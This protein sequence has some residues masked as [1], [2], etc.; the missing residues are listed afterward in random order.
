MFEDATDTLVIGQIV[1]NGSAGVSGTAPV[2]APGA[3]NVLQAGGF[4]AEI[5]GYV[6]GD[7]I[8][9]D[10]MTVSS[11]SVV[12]GNTVDLFGPGNVSLGSL[13]FFT[14]SGIEGLE[15]RG[16]GGGG[17]DASASPQARG[18]RRWTGWCGSRTCG[19]GDRAWSTADGGAEPIV[20][21]G[22]RDG[23]LRAASEAGDGVAGARRG[24]CVWRE[25]SGARSVS[26]PRS[27]GVR[28]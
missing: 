18:S 16:D 28:E 15:R 22:Q 27:R 12:N 23:E 24:R 8:Q 5:W 3:E 19:S 4:A 25:R 17:A 11:A 20:W 9:F 1:N 7:K 26:V 13:A 2:V 14:K 6:A 10:N 21:I